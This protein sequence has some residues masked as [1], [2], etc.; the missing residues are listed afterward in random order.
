MLIDHAIPYIPI[1]LLQWVY[2]IRE[3]NRTRDREMKLLCLGLGRTGT[4]SLQKALRDL[5]YSE[6]YHGFYLISES[7]IGDVLQWER[8]M[9]AKMGPSPQKDFLNR[10]EFDKVLGNCMA[11]TDLPG[12]FLGPELLRAYPEAKVVLNRRKDVEA[13]YQSQLSTI[14]TLY[15][16]WPSWT[17]K[18]FEP[19]TFYLS[20]LVSWIR[21]SNDYDFVKNGKRVYHEHYAELEAELRAQNRE[22][23]D[24]T[25]EDGWE[26][27]CNFLDLPVPDAPFPR[28]N[29]AAG[30]FA[31]T[32]AR[33]HHDRI[34]KAYRNMAVIG[35][36]VISV[37]ATAVWWKMKH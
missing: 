18:W 32:R 26:P 4:E 21:R 36:I 31:A 7:G 28:G 20:E 35:S 17:R 15:T 9:R 13:W 19:V 8:L 23:L 5:D 10:E 33:L 30:Q 16:D 25:V 1:P 14:D 22:W 3:N 6:V 37:A 27:L 34:L 24:W 12:A 11:T 2:P 29:A